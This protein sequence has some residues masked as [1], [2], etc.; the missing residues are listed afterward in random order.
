MYRNIKSLTDFLR[1]SNWEE[2]NQ[3]L[4]RYLIEGFTLESL[5]A[6]KVFGWWK[7]LGDCSCL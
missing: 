6:E 4:G 7:F 2:L 1:T 5:V 3:F